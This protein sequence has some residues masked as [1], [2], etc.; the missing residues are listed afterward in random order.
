LNAGKCAKTKEEGLQQQPLLPHPR[1]HGGQFTISNSL[2][3]CCSHNNYRYCS[4]NHRQRLLCSLHH[5][6]VFGALAPASHSVA[7]LR[8]AAP[9]KLV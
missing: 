1:P 9:C 3:P 4:L 5:L 7:S 2:S 8:T 6:A